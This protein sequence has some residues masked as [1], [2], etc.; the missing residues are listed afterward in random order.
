MKFELI[1]PDRLDLGTTVKGLDYIDVPGN[2]KRDYKLQFYAHK[3]GQQL[4]KVPHCAT[5]KI[6]RIINCAYSINQ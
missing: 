4:L 2:G 5:L 3:E 1:K 6:K